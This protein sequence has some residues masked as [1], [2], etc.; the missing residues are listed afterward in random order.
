MLLQKLKILFRGRVISDLKGE[1]IVGT[2]Y[3]R[4]LQ[5]AN[6]K[7]F[8]FGKVIKRKSDQLYVKWKDYDNS[9]NS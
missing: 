2:F 4:E 8:R 6:R 5:I 3:E 7:Y 1:K 9:F